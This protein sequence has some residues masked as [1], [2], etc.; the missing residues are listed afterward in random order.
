M[1]D[2]IYTTSTDM[3]TLS[4]NTTDTNSWFILTKLKTIKK[5]QLY[6]IFFQ[7]KRE[8]KHFSKRF[9]TQFVCFSKGSKYNFFKVILKV[10]KHST[11][12]MPLKSKL[13]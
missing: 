4:N 8:I 6:E 13:C 9:R 12:L 11:I 3:N 10:N 7:R 5:F 2:N 1:N